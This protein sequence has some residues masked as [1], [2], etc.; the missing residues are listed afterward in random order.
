[1]IEPVVLRSGIIFADIT[2]QD[3]SFILNYVYTV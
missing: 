1:M 2:S 3:A